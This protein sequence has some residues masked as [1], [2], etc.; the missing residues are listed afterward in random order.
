M[1]ILG[2]LILL[3]ATLLLLFNG[4]RMKMLEKKTVFY[5]HIWILRERSTGEY[6]KEWKLPDD[7]AMIWQNISRPWKPCWQDGK[8]KMRSGLIWKACK[9]S[10][11]D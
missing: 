6:K 4:L 9:K 3:L 8:T 2:T 10:M 1:L 7:I 11:K 5:L